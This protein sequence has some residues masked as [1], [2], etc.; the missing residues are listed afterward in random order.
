LDRPAEALPIYDDLLGTSTGPDWHAEALFGKGLCEQRLGNGA[1]AK[2]LW[3]R[4]RAQY[5]S[6]RHI[7][8]VERLLGE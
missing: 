1:A 5:P 3:S 7:A 8:E 2:E 4:Y 6:G